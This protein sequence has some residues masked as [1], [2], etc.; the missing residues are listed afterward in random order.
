ML[1]A[2]LATIRTR[3]ASGGC[4]TCIILN[5]PKGIDVDHRDGDGLNNRRSNIRLA[6]PSQNMSN[7]GPHKQNTSGYKG[8]TWNKARSKWVA[9]ISFNRR[10]IGLGYFTEKEKAIE[11]YRNA[12]SVLHGEF[13]RFTP[14]QRA[15]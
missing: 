7:H 13:A 12:A 15:A 9:Q 5:A 2:L 4:S 8:V 3:Q 1:G 14:F 6:T 11:A 10:N